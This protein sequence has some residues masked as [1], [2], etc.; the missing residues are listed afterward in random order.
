MILFF[1]FFAFFFFLFFFFSGPFWFL[2]IGVWLSKL[3]LHGY[4]E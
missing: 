3:A 1:F 4:V 2:D